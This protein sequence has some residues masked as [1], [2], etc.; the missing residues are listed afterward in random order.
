MGRERIKREM[1]QA[2][3]DAYQAFGISRLMGHVVALLLYANKPLSLDDIAAELGMSKGPIS[4]VTRRLKD[5]NLIRK[6]WVPGTRKDFYEV[7]PEIFSNAFRNVTALVRQNKTIASTLLQE[8]R[9]LND[10][11]IQTLKKRLEEME[12]FYELMLQYNRQF[13]KEWTGEDGES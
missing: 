5:H 3:G 7:H 13:L 10:P 1:I 11:E 6:V 8:V 2:F 4:Q 12:R 9:Q